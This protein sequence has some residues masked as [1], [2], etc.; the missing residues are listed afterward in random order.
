MQ[1]FKNAVH[2][3]T[4]HTDRSHLIWNVLKEI[5]KVFQLNLQNKYKKLTKKYQ[6]E[7]KRKIMKL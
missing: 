5:F 3:V 4:L 1:A 6:Q 7:S 2:H